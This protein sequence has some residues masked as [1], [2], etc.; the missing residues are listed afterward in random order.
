MKPE[1]FLSVYNTKEDYYRWRIRPVNN[2]VRNLAPR[3]TVKQV[4]KQV[5]L[6]RILEISDA[7][8]AW[9]IR[10]VFVV[11]PNSR[12]V[13]WPKELCPMYMTL[14]VAEYS[15][16]ILQ[17]NPDLIRANLDS[18]GAPRGVMRCPSKKLKILSFEI[19][20]IESFDFMKKLRPTKMWV[21]CNCFHDIPR[22]L[23]CAE[24][25]CHR[26]L[27]PS[28]TKCVIQCFRRLQKVIISGLGAD[29]GMWTSFL[30]RGL[31]DPRLFVII[32]RFIA[33]FH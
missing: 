5:P 30:M 10:C 25:L 24:V 32:A 15:S 19:Q 6:E 27:G 18:N 20:C 33:V 9:K 3:G 28:G 22:P 7:L 14:Q 11:A 23:Q 1:A 17:N 31:Y 2:G 21:V 13:S 12:I 8:Y 29:Q 16:N 4:G 26:A